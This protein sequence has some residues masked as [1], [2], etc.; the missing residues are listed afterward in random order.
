MSGMIR[1]GQLDRRVTIL[2]Q[3]APTHDGLQTVPGAFA[4]IGSRAASVRPAQGREAAEFLGKE[5]HAP[6]SIW[7]R[8][9]SLTRTIVATDAIEYQGQ[10]YQILAPPVEVGRREGIELLVSAIVRPAG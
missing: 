5:A 4:P 1:A 9:D 10:R 7:L 3:G 2:R 8:Y 6:M